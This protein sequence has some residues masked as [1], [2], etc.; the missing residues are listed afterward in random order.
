MPQKKTNDQDPADW[1]AF[2]D[3]RLRGVDAL[4]KSEGVTALGVEALQEGTE[5]YLKGY[6]IAKGW[7]LVRTH[8]LERLIKEAAQFNRAFGKYESFA[9]ELTE[10]FFAQHYPG[11]DLTAFGQ[12]YE[13]LRKQAGEVVELIRTSLPKYFTNKQNS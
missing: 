12:N 13:Q 2:A 6:L 9:V 8:D 11:G 7:T 10:E 4:F 3:E 1:F 5:R